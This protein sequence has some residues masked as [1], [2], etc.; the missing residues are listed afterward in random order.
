[1]RISEFLFLTHIIHLSTFPRDFAFQ[2]VCNSYSIRLHTIWLP[3]I[4]RSCYTKRLTSQSEN[5]TTKMTFRA[6]ENVRFPASSRKELPSGYLP[7]IKMSGPPRCISMECSLHLQRLLPA[8]II[9]TI[10]KNVATVKILREYYMLFTFSNAATSNN[11]DD[12]KKTLP[13]TLIPSTNQ[14]TSPTLSTTTSQAVHQNPAS[15]SML[16]LPRW[17]SRR[18]S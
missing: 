15:S 13:L 17:A 2:F 4:Y 7:T 3:P 6:L 8:T 18:S 16:E 14:T 11:R 10:R 1:M 12:N 5:S 9:I